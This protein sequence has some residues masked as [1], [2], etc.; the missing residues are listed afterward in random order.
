MKLSIVHENIPTVEDAEAA[1][2]GWAA[3]GS[4]LKSLLETGKVLPQA[5]WDMHAEV[6]DA[7]MRARD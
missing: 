2:L 5:P 1:A 7:R 6:R 4:N 3:V